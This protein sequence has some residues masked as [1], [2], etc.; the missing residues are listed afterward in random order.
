MPFNNPTITKAAKASTRPRMSVDPLRPSSPDQE[1]AAKRA[2]AEARLQSHGRHDGLCLRTY[3]DRH[4]GP[5]S[6]TAPTA[7]QSPQHC[8]CVCASCWD[9]PTQ[10]CVCSW[11]PCRQETT[12]AAAAAATPAYRAASTTHRAT[13]SAPQ[14]GFLAPR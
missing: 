1:A 7:A 6:A 14:V 2:A 11:C 4:L 3:A 5:I 13:R 10:T 12:R 8:Y 9:K